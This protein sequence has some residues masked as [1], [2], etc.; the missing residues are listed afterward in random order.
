V[1]LVLERLNLGLEIALK[2]APVIATQRKLHRV[3]GGCAGKGAEDGTGAGAE[4]SAGADDG[5]GTY[6]DIGWHLH[7]H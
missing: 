5:A 4:N 3:A 6:T 2:L 7:W 1:L